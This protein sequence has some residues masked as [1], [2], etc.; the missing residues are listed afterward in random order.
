MPD[1]RPGPT[2]ARWSF[3]RVTLLGDAA[4]P[5]FPMGMDGGSQSIIDARALAWCLAKD[6]EP[7]AALRRYDQIRREVVNR[8][9]LRNRELGPEEI[10]ARAVECGGALPGPQAALISRD[11]KRV[12]RFTTEHVNAGASWTVP[13][14]DAGRARV[15]SR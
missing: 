6:E 2:G 11:Y 9:V 15:R 14:S 8:V 4:H 7:V 5:M 12:A 10:I 13:R 1:A 3:G